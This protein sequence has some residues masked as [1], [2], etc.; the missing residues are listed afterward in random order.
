MK[1]IGDLE[2]WLKKTGKDEALAVCFVR[3]TFTVTVHDHEGTSK[4]SLES[5]FE[6]AME[7]LRR[8]ENKMESMRKEKAWSVDPSLSTA[9][10]VYITP[11]SKIVTT[12]PV[13]PVSVNLN[14]G[15]PAK[16][17]CPTC[18]QCG[19][20]PVS[21]MRVPAAAALYDLTCMNYHSWSWKPRISDRLVAK[22]G[23]TVEY[24]GAA[25]VPVP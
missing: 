6:N 11:G 2:R 24:D 1:T 23:V 15:A 20:V 22:S 19:D 14:L 10:S 5:A 9:T 3:G 7:E 4:V 12:L 21:W 18:P 8:S 16:A 25:L 13:Y 17:P